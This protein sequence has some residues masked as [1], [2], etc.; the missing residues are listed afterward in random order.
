MVGHVEEMRRMCVDVVEERN[1]NTALNAGM[2]SMGVRVALKT[3]V[4]SAGRI[5]SMAVARDLRFF[6]ASHV[7]QPKIC[8]TG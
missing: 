4:R 2:L 7:W 5:A 6:R 1:E 8:P 3:E